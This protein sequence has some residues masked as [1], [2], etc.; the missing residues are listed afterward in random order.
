MF[1]Q[2]YPQMHLIQRLRQLNDNLFPGDKESD[3]QLMDRIDIIVKTVVLRKH[4]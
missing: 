1:S 3:M 4:P 2:T